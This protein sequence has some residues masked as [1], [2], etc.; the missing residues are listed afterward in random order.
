MRKSLKIKSKANKKR[1]LFE[2]ACLGLDEIL[3]S[4]FYSVAS[5]QL[6][7]GLS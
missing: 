6:D 1:M 7:F 2:A 3:A 4:K 5:W